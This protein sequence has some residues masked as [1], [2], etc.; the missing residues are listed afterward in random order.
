LDT[1]FG[2][3]R[4]GNS[5]SVYYGWNIS[6]MN[7]QTGWNELKLQFSQADEKSAIPFRPGD[8]FD[9]NTGSSEVDFITA[10]LEV[11]TAT[12]GVTSHRIEQAPGIRYWA[13]E[14]KGNKSS[15][16]NLEITVDDFNFVR[17]RF[18][19]VCKFDG[20]LYLNNSELFTIYLNGVD[21]ATGTVEFW[22]RPDWDLGGRIRRGEVVLPAL[23]RILR[24]DGKFL[25]WFYRPNQGFIC[26]IFDG[27]QLLQAVSNVVSY[28]FEANELM[29]VA[30][31]WS[32]NRGI[33]PEDASIAMFING[34][35]IYGTDKTWIGQREGGNTV[36]IGG[37]MG[38]LFSSI[39]QNATAL[40]FTPIPNIPT[41]LTASTWGVIENLKIYNYAKRYF[42]DREEEDLQVVSATT[43]AEMIEIS[44]T[45]SGNDFHGLGSDSLPLVATG[46]PSG[47]PVSVYIRTNIPKGLDPEAERDA[48]LIVRWKTPLEECE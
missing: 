28:E 42:D 38:Q 24:P 22:F 5:S 21:L 31:S 40:T 46:I 25:S 43:P 19:D 36:F 10:D 26:S 23:F 4:L 13:M 2:Q 11:S 30:L 3:I 6:D 7:L 27:Q 15:A 14:F 29:H 20:S 35:P 45:A 12:D 8:Q 17:N 41:D 16:T 18:D 1:G 48:S 37:E 9:V 32:A 39:P 44:L 33:G 34:K 47:E